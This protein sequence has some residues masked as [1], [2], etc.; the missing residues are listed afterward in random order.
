MTVL[1]AGEPHVTPERVRT[2]WRIP[3]YAV[4]RPNGRHRHFLG[5]DVIGLST[6]F[7]LR[8]ARIWI[9]ARVLAVALM[10]MAGSSEGASVVRFTPMAALLVVVVSIALGLV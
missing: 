5:A 8:A 2:V 7:L 1:V 3:V 9:L 4:R 10:V 6:R